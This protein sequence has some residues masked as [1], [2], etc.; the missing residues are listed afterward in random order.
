MQTCRLPPAAL[1]LIAVAAAAPP[2]AGQALT[3]SADLAAIA[4]LTPRPA[5][6]AAAAAL[7]RYVE[8]RLQALSVPRA[9]HP[10]PA[11]GPRGA[12]IATVSG[13]S[14]RTVAHLA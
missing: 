5:G 8:A 11:A 3:P 2:A 12:L 4:A 13:R 14:D 6:S 9:F 10:L 1:L 7:M